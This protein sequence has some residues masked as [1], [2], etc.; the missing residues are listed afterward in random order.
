MVKNVV[1]FV[2]NFQRSG[3]ELEIELV[4]VHTVDVV[5]EVER[6]VLIIV[7]VLGLLVFD[8][9]LVEQILLQSVCPG[10]PVR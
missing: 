7:L 1:R 3:V 5:V 2:G 10:N 9:F 6:V 8:L 4:D